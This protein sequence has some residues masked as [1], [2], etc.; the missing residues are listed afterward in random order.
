L[1]ELRALEKANLVDEA[2]LILNKL[3]AAQEYERKEM[4]G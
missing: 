4:D 1:K 2:R 3:F